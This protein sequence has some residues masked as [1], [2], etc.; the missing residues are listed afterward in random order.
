MTGDRTY[1]FEGYRVYEYPNAEFNPTEAK[2]I[3]TFDLNNG[4][5]RV[6]EAPDANG[7]VRISSNGGDTGVQRSLKIDNLTNYKDYYYGVEAY[8]VNLNTDVNR[9]YA[10][11]IARVVARPEPTAANGAIVN[12]SVYGTSI[13]GTKGATNAGEGLA[14]AIVVNP[15]QLT[16]A[17]YNVRFYTVTVTPTGTTTPV[18]ATTYDITNAATGAKVFDGTDYV[19]RTGRAAP[20]QAPTVSETS[21][22]NS[23]LVQAEGLAFVVRG[24]APGIKEARIT[25]NAAGALTPNQ[26]A[27]C[28]ANAQGFPELPEAPGVHIATANSQSTGGAVMCIHTGNSAGATLAANGTYAYFLSRT[29]RDGGNLG[30]LGASDY[31]WRWTGSSIGY[32]GFQNG[33]VYSVPFELWDVG[34]KPDASDDIRMIPLIND[35]AQAGG[36]PNNAFNGGG[37]DHSFSGGINDAQS[38]WVYW[39]RPSNTTP[40]Q[41]GYNAYVAETQT[42]AG[43]NASLGAEVF[44]RMV[45]AGFNNGNEYV[46]PFTRTLPETG[47]VF[48][49]NTY[50]PNQPG[51]TFAINTAKASVVT[52]DSL[53]AASLDQIG[54]TPNPYR[55]ASAYE[56]SN[57]V[58]I[59]RFT[60]LPT[61][62]DDSHLHAQRHA[63]PDAREERPGPLARLGPPERRWPAH[64]VRHVPHSH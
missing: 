26:T 18:T 17:T 59:A 41:A 30:A 3:G 60:G 4:I 46:G 33:T 20:Q 62:G 37:A 28:D 42:P 52:S 47:T 16:G 56:V 2:L 21:T 22:D 24:P 13:A 58:D 39:Y 15:A 7:E 25:R 1:N 61:A 63:D 53:I 14:R 51:D 23:G 27:F 35:V 19:R 34:T 10:S 5:L 36:A 31:E 50:K 64:L 32:N 48:R 54:I 49:I 43:P 44:A 9:T 45:T 12:T 29:L 6:L 57:L 55:G 8:A 40:G 38:D 11:T